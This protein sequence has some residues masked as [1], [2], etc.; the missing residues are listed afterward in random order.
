MNRV[1]RVAG[2]TSFVVAILF[3][4]PF[5]VG[6]AQAGGVKKALEVVERVDLNRYAGKWFEIARYPNRFQKDCATDTTATYTLRKDGKIEVVNSCLRKDDKLKTARGTAKVV[7]SRTN[8]KLKVTF[9]WPF[10]GDYWIID[11]DPEYRYA[12]VGDPGRK[13]LWILSRTPTLDE[14]TYQQVLRNVRTAGYD[15][16]RLTKTPQTVV[17]Q[18]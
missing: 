18:P 2:M 8:A 13:Y 14:Q 12:V 3:F 4:A 5:L 6:E 10:Y 7:D 11:L 1:R 15:P 16:D 9:F 17:A